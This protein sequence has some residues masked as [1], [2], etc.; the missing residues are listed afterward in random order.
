MLIFA[1]ATLWGTLGWLALSG[2]ALVWAATGLTRAAEQIAKS[3][4][5][6]QLWLGSVLLAAATSLPELVTDITAVRLGASDLAAGD[7]FG[8]S[9]A[10][11][12]ILA[13]LL[14]LGRPDTIGWRFGNE[15][16]CTAGLAW[17]L[18][19]IAAM[20]VLLRPQTAWFGVAPMS[21]LLVTI[22]LLWTRSAFA[23]D[24]AASIDEP[25]P[26]QTLPGGGS[27]YRAG[28][29]FCVA[30][31]AIVLSAPFFAAAAQRLAELSGLGDTFVGTAIVG[32]STSLPELVVSLAALR[33]G[34]SGLAVGNLFGSNAF[35]M[36]IFA[37]MDLVDR[38]PIFAALDPTHA[39]SALGA[40]GLMAMGL[41]A[42]LRPPRS[43]LALFEPS[44]LTLMLAYGAIMVTLLN[45]TGGDR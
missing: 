37:G 21:L 34:A 43:R 40:I 38:R 32:L 41:S 5:I 44:G 2:L 22:Y 12:M 45:Y 25:K 23:D 27:W 7:L 4:G 19:A 28:W 26:S 8:S 6:G 9:M 17:L 42:V 1:E 29:G 15:L 30:A 16:T 31:L 20:A 10:N 11:M 36:L 39:L 14:L 35:N 24:H 33:L 13:L 18:T 3:T